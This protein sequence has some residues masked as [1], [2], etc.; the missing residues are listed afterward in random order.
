MAGPYDWNPYDDGDSG[1]GEAKENVEQNYEPSDPDA[2][3]E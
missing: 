2:T 3:T 1:H